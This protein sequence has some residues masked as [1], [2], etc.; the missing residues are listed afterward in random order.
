MSKATLQVQEKENAGR[1]LYAAEAFRKPRS[2]LIGQFCTLHHVLSTL[3][4]AASRLAECDFDT[5][6]SASQALNLSPSGV[7]GSS[8]KL[9]RA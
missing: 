9:L 5:L 6:I 7:S 3:L 4:P 1:A 2:A 8:T